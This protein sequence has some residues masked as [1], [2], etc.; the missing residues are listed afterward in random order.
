MWKEKKKKWYTEN[1]NTAEYGYNGPKPD[2]DR[3]KKKKFRFA[4]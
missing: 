3:T 4:I 1:A 2:I